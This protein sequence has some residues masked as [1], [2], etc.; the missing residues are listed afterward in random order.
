MR[1]VTSLPTDSL[2]GSAG[3][4]PSGPPQAASARVRHL[5]LAA[6]VLAQVVIVVTGGLVRL[7]ASGL[8]CPTWPRCFE[9]SYVPVTG[10]PQS[11]H[12]LIE[13]SNRMLTFVL[14][15]VLLAC[16]VVAWR[17]VPRRR[18]LVL[19]AAC[20]LLGV[21]AQAVIGGLSVLTDLNP[22]VVAL[23]FLVSMPLIAAALAVY[24]RDQDGGDGDAVPVV[25]REVR[26]LAF[27]LVALA[28]V[29]LVIGTLVTG[30]GP[31]SGDV[32]APARTGFD[33]ARIAWLHADVV[34][35]FVGLVVAL[36]LAL[37]LSDAPAL[38]RRRARVLLA[39]TLGQGLIGYVQ[40]FT[41]VPWAL[42]GMHVLGATLLWVAVL[43]VLYATRT[44][45]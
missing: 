4:V 39:V 19:L 1:P 30:S 9:G 6:G 23:H 12:K 35:L 13:F 17:R 15:A 32:S 3:S 42:V 40:F 10:Q 21:A 26:S 11:F 37:H 38:V 33:P 36:L 20:G 24:E 43:R 22:Y 34:V 28:S 14:V 18:S 29:I 41:G 27:V 44:R 5:V 31:H 7:T 25:R 45:D 16:V 2:T 8:G